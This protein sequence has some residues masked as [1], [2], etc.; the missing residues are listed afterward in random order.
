MYRSVNLEK[1]C[2]IKTILVPASGSSSDETVFVTALAAAKPC[3]AH[4]QFYHVRMS[5]DIA[6]LRTPHLDFCVGSGLTAGLGKVGQNVTALSSQAGAHVRSFCSKHKLLMDDRPARIETVCASYLEEVNEEH[7]RLLTQ[8]RHSDLVIL[9]R[10]RHLDYMPS[11]LI[12]DLLVGSGRP[13]II[14]PSAPPA[15]PLFKTIIIGWKE[16]AESAR[17]VAAAQPYLEQADRVILLHVVEDETS[18]PKALTHLAQQLKWHGVSAEARVV[19]NGKNGVSQLL[20]QAAELSADLL[21][22]GAFGHSRVRELVFGGV[23]RSLIDEANVPV[24]MAC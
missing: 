4:L 16:S 12:E 5:E 11:I 22:V 7:E 21:V 3:S 15:S 6:A 17:A 13:I 14:A 24:F 9:G 19:P 2:M 18:Q 8:A 23:T 1:A 20:R 10:P